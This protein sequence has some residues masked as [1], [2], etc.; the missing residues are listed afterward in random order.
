MTRSDVLKKVATIYHPT[1]AKYKC[2]KC[3]E[4]FDEPDDEEYEVGECWGMPAYDDEDVCP[5]CGSGHFFDEAA[6]EEWRFEHALD[7]RGAKRVVGK[8]YRIV[9]VTA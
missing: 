4:W 5:C 3:G 9:R 7:N 6:E 8:K 2:G 1:P